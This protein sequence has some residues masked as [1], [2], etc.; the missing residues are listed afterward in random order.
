MS[1]ILSYVYPSVD[2]NSN[3]DL[4]VVKL[5]FKKLNEW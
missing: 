3:H 1:D 5:K 4:D 2:V